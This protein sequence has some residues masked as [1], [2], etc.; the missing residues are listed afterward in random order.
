MGNLQPLGGG[1]EIYVSPTHRFGTDAILLA[2]FA[3]IKGRDR[4]IDLGTGCGIIPF[5]WCANG[6][7]GG[8]TAVEISGAAADMAARSARHNGL[9][10]Q[11]DI[12][13]ADLRRLCADRPELRGAFTLVTMNPPYKAANDGAQSPD[14]E[15]RQARHEV[16]CTT[17]DVCNCAAGLLNFGGRLCM[18]QRPD[19]LCDLIV[20][21]RTAGI[22][23]K[24]LRMVCQRA[25][26]APMLILIEGKR[27]GRPGLVNLPPLYVEGENGDFSPEML[28]IY[29]GFKAAWR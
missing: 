16:N 14:D 6:H 9:E 10:G 28:D 11:V 5:L 24:R 8:I 23:P 27:G 15:R 20:S 21:M 22:E 12:I 7:S 3:S 4:A 19:R 26:A 2:D 17:D 1:V 18:C 29:G 13:N 25:G